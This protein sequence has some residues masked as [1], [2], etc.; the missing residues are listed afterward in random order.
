MVIIV[1]SALIYSAGS[2]WLR[3]AVYYWQYFGNDPTYNTLLFILCGRDGA[4]SASHADAR[5][6]INLIG[7]SLV[8][9][10]CIL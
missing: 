5:G 10:R 6:F 4:D 1:I 7:G 8:V 3:S 9:E 2:W